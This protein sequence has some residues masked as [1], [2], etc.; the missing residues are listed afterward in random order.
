[1]SSNNDDSSSHEGYGNAWNYQG[2]MFRVGLEEMLSHSRLQVGCE[3]AI[4]DV[5][6]VI[7]PSP[8][9]SPPSRAPPGN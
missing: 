8:A 7:A 5:T 9:P 6:V 4:E 3:I 2:L 1:M